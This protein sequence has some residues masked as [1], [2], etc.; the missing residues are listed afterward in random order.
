MEDAHTILE[1]LFGGAAVFCGVFDGHNGDQASKFC[2]EHLFK[3]IERRCKNVAGLTEDNIVAAAMEADNDFLNKEPWSQYR[4]HGTTAVFVIIH[5]HSDNKK[6]KII[7]GN[8]GDSRC[9]LLRG[10][11][12]HRME[13]LTQD[14]KPQ[15][16]KEEQRIENAGGYVMNDRVNGDLA[17]SRAFGDSPYKSNDGLP[18]NQQQVIPIPDITH[19]VA[20]PGDHLLLCCDGLVEALNN[21]QVASCVFDSLAKRKDGD[22]A[23][24][25]SELIDFSLKSGSKDNMTAMLVEFKDGV[26][27]RQDDEFIPGVIR[28]TK[29]EYLQ[30]YKNNCVSHG[31]EVSHVVKRLQQQQKDVQQTKK[32]KLNHEEKAQTQNGNAK[33]G[34][35]KN[36]WA[37]YVE[38]QLEKIKVKRLLHI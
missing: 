6:Y 18:A 14:H 19:A 22:L 24:V 13:E 38:D 23:E 2:S 34:E 12:Q 3:Y 7:V 16:P 35:D 5:K 4:E 31:F 33:A 26:S 25:V 17:L 15:N 8:V 11:A 32:R 10:G 36:I 27:Y 1:P 29:K 30:H 20:S 9:L 21:Q 28:T 37:E